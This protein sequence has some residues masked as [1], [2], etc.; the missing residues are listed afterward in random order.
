MQASS[1]ITLAPHRLPMFGSSAGVKFY[2]ITTEEVEPLVQIDRS[3]GYADYRCVVVDRTT[4]LED[5]IA[6]ELG[7]PAHILVVTPGILFES[8]PPHIVGEQRKLAV[9][10]CGST[11]TSVE[12]ICHFLKVI[13]ESD[14]AGMSS[15]AEG[16]FRLLE[17]T[18]YLFVEDA[19][20]GTAAKFAHK[21]GPYEWFEQLGEL[22]WGG[23]QLVPAG[24][25]SV[26][27]LFHGNYD[28]DQRLE[29]NGTIALHGQ[30]ILHSGRP[31]F[32]EADQTRIYDRLRIMAEKPVIC[33][34]ENGQIV[35]AAGI[36]GESNDA[37]QML[38]C[39]FE[40]DSRYRTIW[41]VGFG[42]NSQHTMYAGNVGMN[43]V[44]GGKFGALHWGL[45]LTPWT[46]FHMDIVCPN[47]RVSAAEG[48]RIL[49][50]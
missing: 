8:P 31:S 50:P 32:L 4:N 2:L 13:E 40:V 16:I 42:I 12:A 22:D 47:I 7:T 27:P 36:D 33:E 43:E 23:Q 35:S 38:N 24:E 9:M 11:P 17:E 14:P 29:I 44:H 37:A 30:P 49:G 48:K 46:Q 34:I 45:G 1:A 15:R 39:L 6:E 10:A 41:E 5:V 3:G 19:K 28:S 26:L 21:A 25:L 20:L 18:E